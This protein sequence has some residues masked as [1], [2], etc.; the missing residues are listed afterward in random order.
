MGHANGFTSN[1]P[2]CSS[3]LLTPGVSGSGWNWHPYPRRWRGN[4]PGDGICAF[5]PAVFQFRIP[6]NLCKAWRQSQGA[7]STT[8]GMKRIM[9]LG[10]CSLLRRWES[11]LAGDR[12]VCS[13]HLSSS[14]WPPRGRESR[15]RLLLGGASVQY[16]HFRPLVGRRKVLMCSPPL[17]L[18]DLLLSFALVLFPA[19]KQRESLTLCRRRRCCMGL[20]WLGDNAKRDGLQMGSAGAF[21]CRGPSTMVRWTCMAEPA[22]RADY[23]MI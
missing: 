16:V 18:M 23:R 3:T 15:G 9:P 17:S 20:L 10:W 4:P 22:H 5:P 8:A 13:S 6:I 12:E 2:S 19:T 7:V 21:C 14:P 1:H 11:S